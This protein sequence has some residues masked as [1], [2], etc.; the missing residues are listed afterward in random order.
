MVSN[1]R[2]VYS[3]DDY[4]KSQKVPGIANVDTRAI[5]RRLRETGAMNGVIAFDS[6]VRYVLIRHVFLNSFS[7]LVLLFVT[8]QC[9]FLL[10]F[11]TLSM[12]HATVMVRPSFASYLIC[13]IRSCLC[14]CVFLSNLHLLA[15][16]RSS[17]KWQMIG[18]YWAR[19]SSRK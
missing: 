4:L 17:Q 18:Q 19:T 16:M 10:L 2:S 8:S 14:L 7:T 1:Y 9:P 11:V 3:L 5:T 6:S 15:V 13:L 12:S